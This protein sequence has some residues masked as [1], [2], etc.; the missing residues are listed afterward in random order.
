M[1]NLIL[2]ALPTHELTATVK[3]LEFKGLPTHFV[4]HEASEPITHTYFINS[5]L[6]SVLNVMT[7]G[8]SVEVGLAGKEGFVGLPSSWASAPVRRKSS[9]K[10]AAAPIR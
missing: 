6:A 9:C 4:L 2:L 3:K 5:G 7:D 8:K 10:L 1:Q